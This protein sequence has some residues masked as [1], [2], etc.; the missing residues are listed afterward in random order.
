ME[1]YIREMQH[2]GLITI[3]K[4]KV[5]LMLRLWEARN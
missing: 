1:R 4:E 3:Q 5:A 2:L